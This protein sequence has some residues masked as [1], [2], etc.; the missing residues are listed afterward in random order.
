MI[1]NVNL[2]RPLRNCILHPLIHT[3]L[4]FDLAQDVDYGQRFPG[5]GNE[6]PQTG[7]TFSVGLII[8]L[9]LH[10]EHLTGWS[11]TLLISSGSKVLFMQLFLFEKRKLFLRI[12]SWR[13]ETFRDWIVFTAVPAMDFLITRGP[14]KVFVTT[15]A[16]FR[17]SR[18]ERSFMFCHWYYSA[19][20]P[21]LPL[22]NLCRA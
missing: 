4:E 13:T 8:K 7:Y 16:L 3:R 11:L 18:G 17:E 12:L 20:S 22:A 10:L 2:L 9:A 6:P 5:L 19:I 1:R 15:W 21:A 14:G